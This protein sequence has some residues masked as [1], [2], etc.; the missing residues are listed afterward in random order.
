ML[1]YM[2]TFFKRHST[3]NKE[4]TL[5]SHAFNLAIKEWDWIRWKDESEI[6]EVPQPLDLLER[7]T[8]FEPATLAL[9]IQ[10]NQFL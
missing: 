7:E 10:F 1:T 2:L 3:V 4:L 9:A 8:G 5:M 6:A